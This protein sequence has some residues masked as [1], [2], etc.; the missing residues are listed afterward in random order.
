MGSPGMGSP[1]GMRCALASVHGG[2][3]SSDDGHESSGGNMPV[4]N[5]AER[6]NHAQLDDS[7]SGSP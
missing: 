7:V 4:C 1:W 6:F 2:F 5:L 3:R